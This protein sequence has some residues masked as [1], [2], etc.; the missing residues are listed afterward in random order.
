M[1]VEQKNALTG[2]TEII[3][4][5]DPKPEDESV[6]KEREKAE[7]KSKINADFS[8]YLIESVKANKIKKA[9]LP[10]A[11]LALIEQYEI[12]AAAPGASGK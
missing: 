2:K 10:T 3:E 5:P 12:I 1:K 9:D 7:I 8:G 11:T 4:V 6:K